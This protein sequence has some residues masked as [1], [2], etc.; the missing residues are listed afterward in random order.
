MRIS[1]LSIGRP[2]QHN[3]L[4]GVERIFLSSEGIYDEVNFDKLK[5]KGAM[6]SA[7]RNHDIIKL[8]N[9]RQILDLEAHGFEL[10]RE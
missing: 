3:Y 8:K 7:A 4:K 6:Q 2:S 1:T 10:I 9:C 5:G